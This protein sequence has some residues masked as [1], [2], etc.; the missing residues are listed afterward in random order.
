MEKEYEVCYSYTLDFISWDCPK[1]GAHVE[2]CGEEL[3][4]TDCPECGFNREEDYILD[5]Y[6]ESQTYYYE[7][8]E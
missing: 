6:D 2:K 4:D 7:E 1:C 5:T 3:Y 8:E